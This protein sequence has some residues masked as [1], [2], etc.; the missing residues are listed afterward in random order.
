M[1][2]VGTVSVSLPVI[3]LSVFSFLEDNFSKCQ[4]SFT[5]F[6]MCI[7]IV[8]IWFGIANG[9]IWS[10]FD[11]VIRAQLFKANDVVS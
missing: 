1:L 2:V 4:W 8:E 9:Q 11:R 5:K 6:D 7:D 10:I 3:H